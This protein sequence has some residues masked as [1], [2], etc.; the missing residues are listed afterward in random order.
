VDESTFATPDAPVAA[1]TR[2]N[3]VLGIERVVLVQ[4]SCHGYDNSAMLNAIAADP[5]RRK[6]W[7]WWRPMCPMPRW[8]RCMRAASAPSS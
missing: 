4:A 6:A 3:R 5:Q 2:M 1:L 8:T 7:R